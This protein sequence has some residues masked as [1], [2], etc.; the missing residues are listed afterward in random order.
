MDGNFKA[1]QTKRKY[2]EDDCPLMN[3]SLFLVEETRHKAYCDAVV[4]TP[5]A[6]CHDHKA[7]SQTNT[8]AK[9]LAVTSIVAVACARHGAFCLGSCANLQKG[10]RQINMDYILCQALKL[11]K[12]PGVTPTMVLYDIICQ[13]GVHVFT[14]FLEHIQFLDF[15][16]PLDITMGIGLFHVHGHQDSCGP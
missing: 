5:Q 3:G 8:Q 4:E 6:T 1:E 14:R 7:Q 9:H 12:I 11:M 10:E 13:Y 16:S 15:D 2:P